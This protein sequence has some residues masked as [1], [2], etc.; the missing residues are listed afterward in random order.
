MQG[1][2]ALPYFLENEG[3]SFAFPLLPHILRVG[4]GGLCPTCEE[5]GGGC[6][7]GGGG[8]GLLS[9]SQVN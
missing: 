6:V 3:A 8:G 4:G 1:G 7:G 9:V 2:G 5:K